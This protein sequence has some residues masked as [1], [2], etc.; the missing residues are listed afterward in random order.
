MPT[1]KYLF[2]HI[3]PASKLDFVYAL[4]DVNLQLVEHTCSM[5]I[6][7]KQNMSL[8]THSDNVASLGLK[9]FFLL[10]KSSH[11]SN[12]STMLSLYKTYGRLTLEYY[13]PAWSPYLQREIDQLESMQRFFKFSLPDMSQLPYHVYLTTFS[14]LSL[15]LRSIH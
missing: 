11:S 15:E 12:I 13:T 8:T 7:Q 14:L 2:L 10:I 5:G 9:R 1:L 6:I 4:G 3:R